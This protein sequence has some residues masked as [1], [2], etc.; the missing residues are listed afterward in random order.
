M[1][2]RKRRGEKIHTNEAILSYQ[3]QS[4]AQRTRRMDL[5]RRL[6]TILRLR[7]GKVLDL[8]HG[9]HGQAHHGH[10]AGRSLREL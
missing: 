6:Q 7:A 8:Q 5:Q 3:Q 4:A 9:A 1:I 10:H 2:E